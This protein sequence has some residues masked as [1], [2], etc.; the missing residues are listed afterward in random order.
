MK[1]SDESSL[2]VHHGRIFSVNPPVA[3]TPTP[4][5]TG[6]STP[7]DT[8]PSTPTFAF[9]PLPRDREKDSG[10]KIHPYLC[11]GFKIEDSI[12]YL[13]DVSHIPPDAWSVIEDRR[14]GGT[15]LP[16][17]VLDCL[18]LEPHTSHLGLA[19]SIATARQVGASRTYLTGFGHEVSHEEYV[20]LGKQ[21]GGIKKDVEQMS[22]IEVEGSGLIAEGKRIWVRPAHD[23]LRVF[24]SREMSVRD[25]SYDFE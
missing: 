9:A 21:A 20:T 3:Y 13:S 16:V 15:T 14:T 10:K 7:N 17:L 8:T 25:G 6:P 11:F 2:L 24:V 23:G 19:Q 4:S 22:P 1:P 12:V 5:G 18:R